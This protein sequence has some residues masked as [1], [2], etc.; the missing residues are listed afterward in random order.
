[1]V[2]AS[3]PPRRRG[4]RGGV[5]GFGAGPPPRGPGHAQKSLRALRASA[6]ALNRSIS[7]TYRPRF[8]HFESAPATWRAGMGFA[9][10]GGHGQLRPGSALRPSLAAEGSRI[11][12]GSY[13]RPGPGHRR[14]HG[15]LQRDQL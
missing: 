3:L 4:G 14:Q 8:G 13:P 1:K 15:A 9:V 12:R 10:G 2:T 11:H 7:V 6:V 5:L